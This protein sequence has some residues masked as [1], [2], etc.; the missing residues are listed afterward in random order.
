[1]RGF[2]G[3]KAQQ[4]CCSK[5]IINRAHS[6]DYCK[7]F[8]YVIISREMYFL[9]SVT[10]LRSVGVDKFS[11]VQTCGNPVDRNHAIRSQINSQLRRRRGINP[12]SFRDKLRRSLC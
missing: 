4:I 6:F 3:A 5:I 12:R 7:I 2:N 1:M 9:N 10:T 8:N 11:Y